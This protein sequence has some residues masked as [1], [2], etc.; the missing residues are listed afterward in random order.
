MN[1]M[2][3]VAMESRETPTERKSQLW[4]ST[5]RSIARTGE[6]NEVLNLF[7]SVS[8]DYD[9]DKIK[10]QD[11]SCDL[12]YLV[13]QLLEISNGFIEGFKAAIGFETFFKQKQVQSE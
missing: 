2:E 8:V 7:R 6:E 11:K 10:N 12:S 1:T 5:S 4:W 3:Q 13:E 9:A